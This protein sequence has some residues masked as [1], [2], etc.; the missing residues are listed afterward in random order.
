MLALARKNAEKAGASNAS[1]VE[2]SITSIPLPDST[3]NCIISNCVV[4]LVPAAEKPVAFQEMFR[5]LAPGGRVAISDILTR[6]PMPDEVTKD[7]SLYVGCIA[8]ASQIHE[9]E[10]YLR[11][12]G[13]KGTYYTLSMPGIKDA[14]RH[15]DIV[16]VDTHKDLNVFKGMFQDQKDNGP[17][18]GCC[19]PK[20]SSCCGTS[21]TAEETGGERLAR[22][23]NEWA[24]KCA[25]GCLRLVC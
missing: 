12:A 22:D 18:L 9:Y 5:L 21:K 2:S 24:G 8:S 14:D 3:A 10:K 19:P 7:L 25:M 6:K 23:F 4:N 17:P 16:I 13:F 11:E 1:F 15:A 20:P